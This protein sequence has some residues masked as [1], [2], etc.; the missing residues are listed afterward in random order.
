MTEAQYLALTAACDAL[1]SGPDA[2]PE[3]IAISW[4]HLRSEHPSHLPPYEEVFAPRSRIV[5]AR[6][7]LVRWTGILATLV[8]SALHPDDDE[9]RTRPDFPQHVDVLFLS[10]LVSEHADCDAADFY[11]GSLPDELKSRGYTSLVALRNHVD[12]P[13]GDLAR[14][15]LRG[16]DAARMVLPRWCAPG[17]EK[18][19]V[20]GVARESVKLRRLARGLQGALE[21]AV[22]RE[23]ARH[24][25]S[26]V[27]LVHLRIHHIVADLCRRLKPRAVFVTWEG[28]AWERLVFHAARSV[29]PMICCVGYQHTIVLPQSHALMRPLG[30]AY[31]P[32][33][34]LT[35]GDVT[36]D[37]I[38]K[39]L[40]MSRISVLTY[41]SHRRPAAARPR[42]AG[43]DERCLVIP[44]GLESECLTLF[45]FA[46]SAAAAMPELE[47]VLRMHP[48]LPFEKVANRHPRLRMLPAN[49]R[50]S[51]E[52]D[53]AV[54]CAQ[55]DWALYRGSS[56]A[57]Y[58]VLAGVRPVYVARPGELV[59]DPL[60]GLDGWRRRIAHIDEFRAIVAAD[61]AEP[62]PERHREWV[63]AASFCERYVMPA[64]P[65]VVDELLRN[66][67]SA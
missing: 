39:A 16:G 29:D 63:R 4:L 59:I 47:F 61:R 22:T 65:A 57:L 19:M 35:V 28:H 40:G 24:A 30:G 11:F 50:V 56:A 13:H 64:N 14:R 6:R 15:W 31:D 2:G 34:I 25:V 7:M 41:G 54:D 18:T 3:R 43:A 32:D 5:R 67:K 10:H 45:D 17:R 49:V 9:S 38:A 42:S 8:R 53:L 20:R 55:C 60:F 44:E 66:C 27:T 36:R 21:R 12:R 51:E 52:A 26:P 58:A 33:A 62:A 23:A 1:L 37:V 46:L 48:V